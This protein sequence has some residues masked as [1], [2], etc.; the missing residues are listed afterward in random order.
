ME[1]EKVFLDS[2]QIGD[3]LRPVDGA[4]VSMLA[5]SMKAIG[6]RHPIT[7]WT[8]DN[9][10]VHLVAGAHR[11]AA[12]RMLGWEDILC[13]FVNLDENERKRWEIA[14]NLH[15]ADL[16]AM[17]RD[18]H[19]AEWVRLTDEAAR[20]AQVAPPRGGRQPRSKGINAA[21]RE[22][23][24]DRTQAQRA[25]KVAGLSQEAKQAAK[26]MSLEDNRSAL[27]DAAKH[28]GADEQVA[29]LRRKAEERNR[30]KSQTHAEVKDAMADACE[31]IADAIA[32]FVPEHRLSAVT[33]ALALRGL[34]DVAARIQSLTGAVFDSTNA[35]RD[36]RARALS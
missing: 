5:E 18:E 26:A 19:V 16:T 8:P 25:I 22:L 30:R 23:G 28:S 34:K 12:A 14:E 1:I 31:I 29:A 24:V 17:Q 20:V 11:L 6:L 21:S 4:K 27:L 36:A 32:E 9:A 13:A 33:A 15:R 2:I 3:R 35:G 10:E 7:V